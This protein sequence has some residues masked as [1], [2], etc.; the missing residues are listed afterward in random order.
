MSASFSNF[1]KINFLKKFF[2]QPIGAELDLT[3]IFTFNNLHIT[4]QYIFAWKEK[5]LD[6]TIFNQNFY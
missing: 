2:D 5:N 6:I 4:K 1:L 3:T